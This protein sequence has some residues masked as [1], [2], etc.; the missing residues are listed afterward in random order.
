[1]LARRRSISGPYSVTRKAPPANPVLTGPLKEERDMR[2]SKLLIMVV[3]STTGLSV[4][5]T[6]A[7]VV[8]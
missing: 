2:I 1:M 4:M 8:A 6:T 5:L 7:S 3:A